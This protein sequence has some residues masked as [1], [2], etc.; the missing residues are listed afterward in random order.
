MREVLVMRHASHRHGVL[1]LSE[2]SEVRDVAVALAEWLIVMNQP[3]ER[4]PT[5][6]NRSRWTAMAMR[7]PRSPTSAR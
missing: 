5:S 3:L 2:R 6:S 7:G 4:T 1:T